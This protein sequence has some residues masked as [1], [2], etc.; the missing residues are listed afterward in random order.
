[1][2]KTDGKLTLAARF[3]AIL[4]EVKTIPKNGKHFQGWTYYKEDDVYSFFRP[5]L[6]EYN[7]GYWPSV[8]EQK[9]DENGITLVKVR[10]LFVNGDNPEDQA[11]IIWHGQG[12]SVDNKGA[13]Q[14]VGG[15]KAATGAFKY[16]MYKL[17][18]I[19]ENDD[20]E[21]DAYA[22]D[23]KANTNNAAPKPASEK[24][25]AQPAPAEAKKTS[26]AKRPVE[27]V[28]LMR[29]MFKRASENPGD[30]DKTKVA[31]VYERLK[32]FTGP[33]NV[34]GFAENIALR[35]FNKSRLED[36]SKGGIDALSDWLA[37]DPDGGDL[38]AMTK[39]ELDKLEKHW[40]R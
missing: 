9:L 37:I 32:L 22:D 19:S 18:M 2:A 40:K 7:I 8:L 38:N 25:E 35:F 13:R 27:P 15:H 28:L 12:R 30:P 21:E 1:M 26:T 39:Q 3:A 4:S 23:K 11:E 36:V 10:L 14:D 29:G 34:I 31:S 5:K 6:A 24:R 33:E 16:A 17:L 20:Q